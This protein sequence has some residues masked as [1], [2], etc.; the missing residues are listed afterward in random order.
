MSICEKGILRLIEWVI[1]S[2]RT[3]KIASA[4]SALSA[5]GSIRSFHVKRPHEKWPKK[6]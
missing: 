2:E 1:E 3:L 4:G 6:I 5:G